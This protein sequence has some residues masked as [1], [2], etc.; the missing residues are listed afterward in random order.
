MQYKKRGNFETSRFLNRVQ[1]MQDI[2][3]E[4]VIITVHKKNTKTKTNK[5]KK[6]N[7]LNA[8]LQVISQN[9]CDYNHT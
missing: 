5:K 4:F 8:F 3:K 9:K 7:N 1:N 2:I 6:K